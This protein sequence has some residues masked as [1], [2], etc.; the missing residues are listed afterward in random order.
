MP[1]EPAA[2]RWALP[3]P[4]ESSIE[5]EDFIGVGADL[6]PGTMLQGYRTGSFGMH[7]DIDDEH[8][9]AWWSPVERGIIPL[10]RFRISR[11]LAR[12]I[13]K[14]SVTFDQAFADVV[15]LCR[16]G[17]RPGDRDGEWITDEYVT[18]YNELFAL[19]WAHSVEVW[20]SNELVG[21]L[22]CIEINGLVCGESMVSRA[23][24]ASKVALAAL[25]RRLN[26]GAKDPAL[27]GGRLLDVQWV[28]PHLAS[29]G[30][31]AVSR[32]TYCAEL[33]PR[34]LQMEPVL[35]AH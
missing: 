31:I 3:L 34:A 15:D 19:G 2:S 35:S 26:T 27:P 16:F 11:S 32:K 13:R 33:L 17:G 30:A 23:R 25:V 6:L 5:D 7:I 24:D 28:T 22:I 1:V 14:Y 12:S 10:D 18:S 21:G 9:L 4:L 29:L 20:H 8:V